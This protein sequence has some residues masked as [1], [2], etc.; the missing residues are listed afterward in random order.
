MF[1]YIQ[2]EEMKKTKDHIKLAQFL[3]KELVGELSEKE[4]EQLTLF[5]QDE[6]K[7]GI[8]SSVRRKAIDIERMER[9]Q[10][11]NV[12]EARKKVEWKIRFRKQAKKA[13][14]LLRYAAV[15]ALPIAIA[16]YLVYVFTVMQPDML[17]QVPTEIKPG[18]TKAQLYLSNGTSVDLENTKQ[19]DIKEVDGSVIKKDSAGLNYQGQVTKLDIR[20]IPENIV[21]TPVGGEYQLILSDGT[22]VWL[23]ALSEIRY[24]IQ[25]TGNSRKVYV[26]GEV[27][28]EVAKN[29]ERPFMVNVG[30]VEVEVLGTQ[31]NIMAY[32]DENN[33][34]TTLVE[35]AVRLKSRDVSGKLSSV[36][37]KPNCQASYN[38]Y[39][40][41]VEIKEVDVDT[42]VAW[43]NGKFIFEKDG[44]SNIMRK[45]E[46]WYGVKVF[47]ETQDLKDLRFSAR[48]DRYGNIEN[49]LKK[50]EQTTK[51]RFEVKNNI[52]LIK[53]KVSEK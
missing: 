39:S 46:R 44:L 32:A 3:A 21:V 15:F 7:R 29:A 5:E 28:F 12:E 19:E 11:F 16:G 30:D 33:I 9:Y 40:K 8:I 10:T 47:F 48:I 23:N 6:E 43:K 42:Y 35:G 51:V 25:F 13:V 18:E 50:M 27:Y 2:E 20:R 17:S 31:F 41:I 14:S 45:L 34:E 38:R 24:P 52:V 4:K 37:L 36:N 53:R 26:S 22:K 49:I 1:Y